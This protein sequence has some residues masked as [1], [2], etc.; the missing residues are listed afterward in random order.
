MR[1]TGKDNADAPLPFLI[2]GGQVGELMRGHDW[3]SSSLG[4]PD[5]WPQ[6]LR[7]VVSLI[8]NSTTP[9]FLAWGRDLALL[10][11]DAYLEILGE[12]HPAALGRP[13]QA[14]WEEI[15]ADI[16]PLVERTLAG[17]AIYHQNAPF[18]ICRNGHEAQ[19]WFTFS[20]TPV[21]DENGHVAGLYCSLTETT[22]Q[23]LAEH[24]RLQE[25]ER[26][27]RLFNQAPS[28]LAVVR[29]PE[30]VFELT[31]ASY[32]ALIGRRNLIGRRVRDVLPELEAQ[33]FIDL[34]D[35]VYRTGKAYTGRAVPI[36][37]GHGSASG[38]KQHFLDFIY[39][40]ITDA[41]GKVSGIFAEGIDVTETVVATAALRASEERF[42]LLDAISEATRTAVDPREIMSRTARLLGEHMGV[43]RCAY[44][45]LE[46]DNDR[47]T[48]RDDWTVPG[49]LSTAGVYSL[50]LFG[51]RAASDMREGR[52]LVIRNTDRELTPSE[53][54]DTFNAIGIKAIICCPL[55]KEGRLV[56][57]MAV[58]HD[59]PRAWTDD[60]IAL[61]EQVVE[62]SWAHIERIR[63]TEALRDADRRKT[64]FLATLAHELRNPLAPIQTGL[65]IM[66]LAPDDMAGI[67]KI[68]DMMERQLGHMIHLVN[69]LL[70][71][72]RITRGMVDLKKERVELKQIMASAIEA[73]LPLIES[74]N[75]ALSLHFPEE[76]LWLDADPTRIAQIV[77]NLLNNAAKYTPG[78]GR[79][80]LSARRESGEVVITVSDTGIGIT[81]ESLQKI[82]DMFTQLEPGIGGAR[83]GL[84][85]GL[86]LVRRLAELHGG[87][88]TAS[89]AGN[90]KGS[91]FTVRLPLAENTDTGKST[92]VPSSSSR[93]P[94]V[95][96]QFKVLVVDDNAD[97]ADTLSALLQI[98]GH[99]ARVANNG[100]QALQIAREFRPEVFFLDIGMPGMNGYE[101]AA[102]LRQMKETE[103]AAIVAV[104]G[105]GT[106]NDRARSREAGFDRHLTKP[107][108]LADVNRI[109]SELAGSPS[110]TLL[111]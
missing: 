71:V 8:I 76:A 92:S 47:F 44:A 79:I 29:G 43:T 26:L 93:Q 94:G 69:D 61:L 39:Q 107:A 85:I 68:R 45:D 33:G 75:H 106:E 64:E 11:N 65:D 2:D 10:Y 6:S 32:L 24:E 74:G 4:N 87:S 102:A 13:F 98:G 99:A 84:G 103:H 70:D 21:R 49:A 27:H 30:H 58:H 101:V 82:F 77:G 108:S 95:G 67:S 19:Y 15:W 51:P 7:T 9:M 25:T 72:A 53:G 57:M 105:W 5:S 38:A 22:D 111:D 55:V 16:G 52:T 34:L 42:R 1:K 86:T 109:L 62:R 80:E 40:P 3:T 59:A 73:N 17:E 88:V 89:S 31:N 100:Q 97:A 20:Y 81:P 110:A 91:S 66:R 48:I 35:Q 28:M 41:A 14:V 12:K 18:V 78:R 90:G 37:L 83:G 50:D 96:R 63:A 56:A 104:T 46:P 54:A 23:V 36:T 60:D